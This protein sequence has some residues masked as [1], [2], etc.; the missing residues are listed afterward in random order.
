MRMKTEKRAEVNTGWKQ[1]VLV[2]EKY[3]K[4]QKGNEESLNVKQGLWT[5]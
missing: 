2:S 3:L 1:E 4:I 5:A